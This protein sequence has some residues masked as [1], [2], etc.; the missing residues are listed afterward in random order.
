MF[1]FLDMFGNYEQRKVDNFKKGKLE[2]DTAEVNDS[3]K[4]YETAICHPKYNKNKWVVVKLYDTKEQAQEGHN[5]WVKKMTQKELPK[6]L[7]DV[8]TAEIAKICF[9][10]EKE[11]SI[12][13]E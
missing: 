10:N 12:K 1:G 9:T 7:K 6:I 4:P 3:D 13:R 5:R 2:I 11:R 8:S